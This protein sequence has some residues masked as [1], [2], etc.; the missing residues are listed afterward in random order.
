MRSEYIGRWRGANK[1]H[2]ILN[3]SGENGDVDIF[4]TESEKVF[5]DFSFFSNTQFA[6][7]RRISVA[8]H[9]IKLTLFLM[10]LV[11]YLYFIL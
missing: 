7:G 10:G 5:K 3:L 9:Y 4:G 11:Y 6:L 2:L 1:D 8:V